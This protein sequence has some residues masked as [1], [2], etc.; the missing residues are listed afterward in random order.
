M[1][2]LMLKNYF[3]PDQRK[4]ARQ[5]QK[6]RNKDA[7]KGTGSADMT[8]MARDDELLAQNEQEKPEP[9]SKFDAAAVRQQVSCSIN[10]I[11]RKKKGTSITRSPFIFKLEAAA[12]AC[13][14]P[15][16][17]TKIFLELLC[18]GVKSSNDK[19]NSVQDNREQ[20]RRNAA[21]KKKIF[22]KVFFNGKEV[23]QS[24]SK[25]I[26]DDFAVP[27]GQIFPIQIVQW[28]ES[29]K[30]QVRVYRISRPKFL[31]FLPILKEYFWRKL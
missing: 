28:P 15:P 9:P 19:K 6:Q 8:E 16:G 23:C 12:R 10:S 14:R 27:I 22:V 13:R 31:E 5:R 20:S 30:L 18:T 3:F 7:E 2:H 29:L 26:T 1:R 17:E 25:P 21:N 11:L 24:T 4:A